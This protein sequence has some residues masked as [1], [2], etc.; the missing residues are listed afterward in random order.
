M[1]GFVSALGYTQ[2]FYTKYNST[3]DIKAG[4]GYVLNTTDVGNHYWAAPLPYLW[5]NS[6]PLVWGQGETA[7]AWYPSLYRIFPA[8]YDNAET[9]LT[10]ATGFGH[11]KFMRSLGYRWCAATG[12]TNGA[13]AAALCHI[14]QTGA[15]SI[16][17][18]ALKGISREGNK[19]VGHGLNFSYK[20]LGNYESVNNTGVTNISKMQHYTV[21]TS[22]YN[23]FDGKYVI[24]IYQPIVR[25]YYTAGTDDV[26]PAKM[27][28]DDTN[29]T[30]AN[31]NSTPFFTAFKWNFRLVPGGATKGIYDAG[32]AATHDIVDVYIDADGDGIPDAWD[33][34]PT[35]FDANNN[36]KLDGLESSVGFNA[37]DDNQIDKYVSSAPYL[38]PVPGLNQV[39]GGVT[40][41]PL[42]ATPFAWSGAYMDSRKNNPA[43]SSL[44]PEFNY[45]RFLSYMGG[46]YIQCDADADGSNDDLCRQYPTWGSA[47][48]T[49]S[50]LGDKERF[51]N[52]SIIG[53]NI[54]L[55][56]SDDLIYLNANNFSAGNHVTRTPA[57]W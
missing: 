20:R 31:G 30:D 11:Q 45:S 7:A 44:I 52:G 22:D 42:L 54:D 57:G 12:V 28:L 21:R 1:Y 25:A 35:Y 40:Y 9:D 27:M 18:L 16:Q 10:D 56:Q 29:T 43:L 15:H 50:I 49:G 14:D 34:R 26:D 46:L 47:G 23:N 38:F 5:K 41:G 37:A 17:E 33:D 55:N 39:F 51:I 36:G 53:A 32:G 4:I 19:C 13:G 8:D 48:G 6:N 2:V 3:N 24:N